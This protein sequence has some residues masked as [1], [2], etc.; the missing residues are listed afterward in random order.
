MDELRAVIGAAG[1]SPSTAGRAAHSGDLWIP[2]ALPRESAEAMRPVVLMKPRNKQASSLFRR[3]GIT[4][5]HIPSWLHSSQ[6]NEA[7]CKV[8]LESN[9]HACD[10]C[11]MLLLQGEKLAGWR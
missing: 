11:W 6:R 5:E 3:S 10:A 2:V 9:S 4:R 1:D 8:M 7:R